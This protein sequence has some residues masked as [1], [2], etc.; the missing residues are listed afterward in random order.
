M[1]LRN[2]RT[3]ALLCRRLTDR[4]PARKLAL[5][6]LGIQL[7]NRAF[8]RDR[9]DLVSAELHCLLD[10]KFHLIRLG[11]SLKKINLRRQFYAVFFDKAQ[12]ADHRIFCHLQ[13]AA[14]VFSAI[15]AVT[16]RDLLADLHAQDV[17][18]MIDIFSGNDDLLFADRA[19]IYKELVHAFL[20]SYF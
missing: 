11:K 3:F 17:F 13:N 8:C 2:D 12:F 7:Y 10:D 18:N 14:S 5:F 16:D 15:D 20:L 19:R 6:L 1:Y 9:N 4:L